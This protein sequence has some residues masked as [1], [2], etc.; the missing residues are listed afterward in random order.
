MISR[1]SRHYFFESPSGKQYDIYVSDKLDKKYVAI[2]RG[3]LNRKPKFIYFGDRG[4][5]HYHDRLGYYKDLDHKDEKR[6]AAY[7]VRHP[8]NYPEG[9]ADWFAKNILW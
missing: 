5:A 9:T 7:Y 6:R 4:Y 1:M 2:E 8:V 3:D